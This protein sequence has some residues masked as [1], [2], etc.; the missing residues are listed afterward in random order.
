MR[1]RGLRCWRTHWSYLS[2]Y[3]ANTAS[4]TPPQ[5][6]HEGQSFSTVRKLAVPKPRQF[7]CGLATPTS[8]ALSHDVVE[9]ALA[10]L[11]AFP[12]HKITA[13]PRG[14]WI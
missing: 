2:N 13:S 8:D 3:V 10:T 1:P 14:T 9:D 11:L 4:R 7:G 5:G 6:I 12:K